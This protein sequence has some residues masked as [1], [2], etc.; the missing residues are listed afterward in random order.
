MKDVLVFG[1]K[2]VLASRKKDCWHMKDVL[3]S[4]KNYVL[5]SVKKDILAT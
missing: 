5:A 1:N 2:N 4:G 3:A